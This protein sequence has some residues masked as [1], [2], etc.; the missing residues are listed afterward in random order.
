MIIINNNKPPLAYKTTY[1]LPPWRISI[2]DYVPSGRCESIPPSPCIFLLLAHSAGKTPP[3]TLAPLECYSH[4]Q[5]S[6][7][8]RT[9]VH[10]SA[11]PATSTH[12]SLL[13]PQ[14]ALLQPLPAHCSRRSQP[15]YSHSLLTAHA[16]ASPATA[17]H[18]SLFTPPLYH[19]TASTWVV[20]S[21][22][23]LDH[24]MTC[25][26]M[27][28]ILDPGSQYHIISWT[29]DRNST[30][31]TASIVPLPPRPVQPPAT[32]SPGRGSWMPDPGSQHLQHLHHGLIQRRRRRCCCGPAAEALAV[33]GLGEWQAGQ[34]P[35]TV[36]TAHLQ[37]GAG[38]GGWGGAGGGTCHT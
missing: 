38:V 9:A 11:S 8:Q 20:N 37:G 29:L 30:W 3:G 17:T 33:A 14:P 6:L 35:V 36:L 27:T 5:R 22:W 19:S 7:L 24:N 34:R 2:H 26:N 25:I 31:I 13:T 18:C 23:I 10:A 16:A 12:C 32:A 15:C 1:T 21:S 28:W 4:V